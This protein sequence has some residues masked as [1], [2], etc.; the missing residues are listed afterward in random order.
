LIMSLNQPGENKNN[1]MERL[2]A[3]LQGDRGVVLMDPPSPWSG[4]HRARAARE[5]SSPLENKNNWVDSDDGV[6]YD[7]D[8]MPVLMVS[9]NS[10]P[11]ENKNNVME[12]FTAWLEGDEGDVID[13]GE[14]KNNRVDSDDDS[15]TMP[16]LIEV[17]DSPWLVGHTHNQMDITA[18]AVRDRIAR[19]G[20][21]ARGG[22][23][24]TDPRG[25]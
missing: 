11:L 7:S 24:D 15:D 14:N 25:G 19:G 1:A 6:A 21:L 9:L 20:T 18:Q 17:D 12:A 3:W 8:A 23:E 22:I 4:A 10:P 2:T 13:T 16:E 5:L